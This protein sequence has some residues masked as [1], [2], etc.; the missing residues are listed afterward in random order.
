MGAG[1]VAPAIV[2]FTADIADFTVAFALLFG[3][4]GIAGLIG[5]GLLITE[6]DN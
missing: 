5:V 1:A 4:L 6:P 2:G 3:S